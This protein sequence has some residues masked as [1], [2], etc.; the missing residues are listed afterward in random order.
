MDRA[1]DLGC[2]LLRFNFRYGDLIRWLGGPYTDSHRNWDEVF[3]QLN[4]VMDIKPPPGFPPL[5]FDRFK[6]VCT[7][8]T[9]LQGHFESNYTDACLRNLAPAPKPLQDSAKE[10]NERI[11]KKNSLLTI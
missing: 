5:D 4:C 2:A 10:V 7:E 11:E 8:G 6:K 1:H 3:D 9:P